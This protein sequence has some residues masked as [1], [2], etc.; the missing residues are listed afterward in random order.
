LLSSRQINDI[1]D[2][3]E[4]M[5]SLDI[6]HG[7]LKAVCSFSRLFRH[8][9]NL[10]Q[11][12]VLVDAEGH[13]RL[14]DFGLSTVLF[15]NGTLTASG[16]PRGTIPYMAP[17]ILEGRSTVTTMS[18]VYA[19]GMVVYEVK[20]AGGAMCNKLRRVDPFSFSAGAFRL[21]SSVTNS[22]SSCPSSPAS[23]RSAQ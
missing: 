19:L 5:H 11:S 13:A 10:A 8:F 15:G 6:V 22:P 21:L 2:G 4:H 23:V 3:L 9:L 17:E 18:D 14:T 1:I 7:D 16:S 20:L 12:N